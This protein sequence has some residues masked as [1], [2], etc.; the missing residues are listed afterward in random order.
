MAEPQFVVR[1]SAGQVVLDSR[2]AAAG[3]CV[4]IVTVPAGTSV[5]KTYPDFVGRTAM[6]I[7]S[8]MLAMP[9][10]DTALGYPR[11]TFTAFVGQDRVFAVFML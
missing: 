8:L 5:T 6:V 9:T 11:V 10:I 4:E 7:A 2:N 3:C 1:N